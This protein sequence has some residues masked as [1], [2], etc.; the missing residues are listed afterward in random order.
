MS[1]FLGMS[2][3]SALLKGSVNLFSAKHLSASLWRGVLNICQYSFIKQFEKPSAPG[4][5]F[6]FAF[7]MDL[8]SSIIVS[9][10]SNEFFSFSFNLA[11]VIV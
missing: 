10:V 2:F 4:A 6:S 5:L 7:S 8:S 1:P 9:A 11:S 3:I